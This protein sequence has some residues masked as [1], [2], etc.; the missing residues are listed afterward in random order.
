MVKACVADVRYFMMSAI[1]VLPCF[2]A[3]VTMF[4]MRHERDANSS[5][6]AAAIAC[7][8]TQHTYQVK[9]TLVLAG[10]C[11]EWWDMLGHGI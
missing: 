9:V 5:G 11:A 2:F 7:E 4:S 1:L 10:A 8:S 6:V 3:M